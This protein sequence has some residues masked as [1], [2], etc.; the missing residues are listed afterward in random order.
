MAVSGGLLVGALGAGAGA[1]AEA[2]T[3]VDS[4]TNSGSGA[5]AGAGAG[6]VVAQIG[7]SVDFPGFLYWNYFVL[8]RSQS[9]D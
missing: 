4:G 7:E 9:G 1:G 8:G 6:R 2:G 3:G 5:G